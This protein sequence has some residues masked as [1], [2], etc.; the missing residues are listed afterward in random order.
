MKTIKNNKVII[1]MMS[2]MA[3]ATYSGKEEAAMSADAVLETTKVEAAMPSH[4][5][6]KETA[7]GPV[8][9]TP[10]VEAAMP[11]DWMKS[12]SG[13]SRDVTRAMTPEE[14]AAITRSEDPKNQQTPNPDEIRKKIVAGMIESKYGNGILPP[15]R[16][17]ASKPSIPSAT[18]KA[19]EVSLPSTKAQEKDT[20]AA[21]TYLDYLYAN[22]SEEVVQTREDSPKITKDGP[23]LPEVALIRGYVQDKRS[24]VGYFCGPRKVNAEE[25]FNLRELKRQPDPF[26][27]EKELPDHKTTTEFNYEALVRHKEIIMKMLAEKSCFGFAIVATA[28]LR[29]LNDISQG[30]YNAK[31]DSLE[32]FVVEYLPVLE[33]HFARNVFSKAGLNQ[34]FAQEEEKYTQLLR[35]NPNVRGDELRKLVDVKPAASSS[36]SGSAIRRGNVSAMTAKFQPSAQSTASASSAEPVTKVGTA[37]TSVKA[38]A[39]AFAKGK[40]VEVEKLKPV[41]R[42][43]EMAKA[44]DGKKS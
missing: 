23:I 35:D 21:R 10:K 18:T 40:P 41:S 32:A 43:R 29:M 36:S 11:S 44:I 15:S 8:L 14:T 22:V 34:L 5:L 12:Q 2:L 26:C 24:P 39:A 16:A 7:V 31:F 27:L 37:T 20:E 33:K 3:G 38:R 13:P 1:L 9:K 28:N 25:Q 30:Y 4:W 19:P 42:V 6:K 17:V